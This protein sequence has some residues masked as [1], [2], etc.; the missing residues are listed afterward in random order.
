[1]KKI[2]SLFLCLCLMLSMALSIGAAEAGKPVYVALGDEI[3]AGEDL[4]EGERNYAQIIADEL[5]YELI[6]LGVHGQTAEGLLEQIN[7]G[8]ITNELA[9][10]KLITITCAIH[11]TLDLVF[12]KALESYNETY[13]PDITSAELMDILKAMNMMDPRFMQLVSVAT[14]VFE[15]DASKGIPP[16]L[17]SEEF[18]QAMAA[19]MAKVDAVMAAI[20]KINPTAAVVLTNQYNPYKNVGGLFMLVSGKLEQGLTKLNEVLATTSYAIADVY[21]PFNESTENLCNASL[22]PRNLDFTPNAAGHAVMA[23]VILNSIPAVNPFV[24]VASGEYYFDPVM[25][26]VENGITAGTSATTFEPEKEC[27]RAQVVTFLWRAA[28]KPE[29]NS[30]NNPFTDVAA[31]DYFYKP[32]LWAVENGITAGM[33]ATT[34]GPNATCT[35]GQVVTFLWRAAGKPEAVNAKNDFV[36]VASGDYFYAPVLWAVENGITAGTGNGQFS[37]AKPCTRGQVVTFLYRADSK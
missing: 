11:D 26:A 27:T 6:N 30:T 14:S 10:A 8:K 18:A 21:T 9:S 1:M 20:Y 24:D 37:P 17:E 34:F 32:V 23:E 2:I 5:G 7:S 36:D 4:N 31:G 3:A 22:T 25:W 28:G 15:G 33:S 12:A 35:R 19:S 13:D 16:Y 29:P